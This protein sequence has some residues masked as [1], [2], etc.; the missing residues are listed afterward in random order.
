MR[1]YIHLNAC[2]N[3]SSKSKAHKL[4]TNKFSRSNFTSIFERSKEGPA[5]QLAP[6]LKKIGA[7]FDLT[8]EGRR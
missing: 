6:L 1:K 7:N 4:S 3:A 2:T 8:T 5:A